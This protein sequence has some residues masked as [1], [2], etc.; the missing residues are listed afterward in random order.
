[1]I[2]ILL[3]ILLLPHERK[4]TSVFVLHPLFPSYHLNS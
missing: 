1:M 2:N 4:V 3:L